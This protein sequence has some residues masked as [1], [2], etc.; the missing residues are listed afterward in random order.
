MTVSF[1]DTFTYNHISNQQIIALIEEYPDSYNELVASL[2]CHTL[3]AQHIWNRR[4]LSGT[5]RH[6][7]WETMPLTELRSINDVHF[8]ESL[9]I[10]ENMDI[11]MEI[12]FSNSSGKT[13]SN[14]VGHILYHI[15]NHSTY[16]R[17]QIV[18]ELKNQGVPVFGTDYIL[19]KRQR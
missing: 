18:S 14:T 12:Q 4:I 13:F 10:V 5:M 7:A 19:Y 2:L 9:E 1:T 8:K 16:H 6:G 17:G 15:V 11:E 3:N